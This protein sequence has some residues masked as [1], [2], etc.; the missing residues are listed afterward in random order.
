MHVHGRGDTADG[1][2]SADAARAAAIVV[3]AE[4][5]DPKSDGAA[6]D[7]IHRVRELNGD[8]LVLAECVDDGNRERLRK[9]G[10]SSVMRPMRGYPEMMVRAVVAPGSEYIIE[11]LFTS[12]GDE[13]LRYDVAVEGVVWGKLASELIVKGMGTPVAYADAETESIECNPL[14]SEPVNAKALYILVKEGREIPETEVVSLVR[15][16]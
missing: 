3:L 11:N 8:C 5:D 9:V 13:C 2:E 6:F 12:L 4:T 1:L 15:A 16:L 10:A 14:A 7:V